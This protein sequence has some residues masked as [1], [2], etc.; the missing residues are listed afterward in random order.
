MHTC[1]LTDIFS[2]SK[3]S[4]MQLMNWLLRCSCEIING[5]SSI[6]ISSFNLSH[7]GQRGIAL[8]QE[9]FSKGKNLTQIVCDKVQG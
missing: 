8:G 3:I 1:S 6:V 7:S 2:V 9:T 5:S 4:N